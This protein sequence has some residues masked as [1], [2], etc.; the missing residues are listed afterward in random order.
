MNNGNRAASRQ[1]WAT[2]LAYGGAG[3]VGAIL[4]TRLPGWMTQAGLSVGAIGLALAASRLGRIA[5]IPAI[6]HMVSADRWAGRGA[7]AI[8]V[9]TA[10]ALLLPFLGFSERG[11]LAVEMIAPALI[12]ALMAQLDWLS[13]GGPPSRLD[14]LTYGVRRAAG[15]AAFAIA[16]VGAGLPNGAYAVAWMMG[17]GFFVMILTGIAIDWGFGTRLPHTVPPTTKADETQPAHIT[18]LALAAILIQTSSGLYHLTPILWVRQGH[19]PA[20][21]GFLWGLAAASEIGFFL[22]APWLCRRFTDWP[23]IL[24][25]LGGAGATIRWVL[26]ASTASLPLLAL[27]QMLQSFSFGASLVGTL[28]LI[29]DHLTGRAR[30]QA[31]AVGINQGLQTGLIPA[32]SLAVSGFLLQALGAESFLI[33]AALAMI[34]TIVALRSGNGLKRAV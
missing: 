27:A 33:M 28:A 14:P 3:C 24:L 12:A 8:S 17:A 25:I 26:I 2:V 1:T 10:F 6:L 19:G 5:I 23:R 15:S 4:S 21:V 30:A 32:L 16:A 20:A 34:G 9:A 7:L 13:L 31:R 22:I 29:R 11:W 18:G